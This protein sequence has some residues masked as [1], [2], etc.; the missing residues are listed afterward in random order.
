MG[1]ARTT[2][3]AGE[4]IDPA[5]DSQ[6]RLITYPYVVRGGIGSVATTM[7]NNTTHPAQANNETKLTD[8]DSDYYNDLVYVYGVNG[9]DQ[10]I[11]LNFREN[12]GGAS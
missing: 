10:A 3:Q 1:E 6:G 12:Y 9:S 5:F 2:I 11:R 8:A 4:L 7:Q